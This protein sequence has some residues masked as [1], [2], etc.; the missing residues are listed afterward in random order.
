MKTSK[1]VKTA[2]KNA[3]TA[4][5]FVLE[6]GR[7]YLEIDYQS[8]QLAYK[9][10][11]GTEFGLNSILRREFY[12]PSPKTF[13][14]DAVKKGDISIAIQDFEGKKQVVVGDPEGGWVIPVGTP[15][16]GAVEN[17]TRLFGDPKLEW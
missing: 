2:R 11:K 5:F 9:A 8:F 15:A 6:S 16:T 4:I 1:S 3:S 7:L 17:L 13:S 12:Q 10:P 14:Y